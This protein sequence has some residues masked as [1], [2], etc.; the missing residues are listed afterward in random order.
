[1]GMQRDQP[2]SNLGQMVCGAVSGSAAWV[3]AYPGDKMKA[4]YID[5]PATTYA[6]CFMPRF[7]KEGIFFLYRGLGASIV[8][9]VPQCGFTM[10]GYQYAKEAFSNKHA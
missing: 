8:R 7:R 4:V 3:V 5:S 10:W 2:V 6:E 1:M 9:G